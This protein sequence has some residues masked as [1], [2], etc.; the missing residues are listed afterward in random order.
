MALTKHVLEP[1][2]KDYGCHIVLQV[3]SMH[4]RI[5]FNDIRNGNYRLVNTTFLCLFHMQQSTGGEK[6]K[7]KSGGRLKTD[8]GTKKVVKAKKKLIDPNV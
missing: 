6:T 3:T 8:S 2:L 1:S 7:T 5:F 4:N